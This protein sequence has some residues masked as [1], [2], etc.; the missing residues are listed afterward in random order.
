MRFAS[1]DKGPDGKAGA[2]KHPP[3]WPEDQAEHRI[4]TPQDERRKLVEHFVPHGLDSLR[5]PSPDRQRRGHGCAELGRAVSVYGE[6]LAD[7]EGSAGEDI[8][9]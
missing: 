6:E 9:A 1:T 3:P 5:L 8:G 2:S 7:V 4:P